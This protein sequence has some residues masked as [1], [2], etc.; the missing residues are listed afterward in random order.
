[1]YSSDGEWDIPLAPSSGAS[2]S[3]EGPKRQPRETQDSYTGHSVVSSGLSDPDADPDYVRGLAQ[4][5]T[6]PEY[7][8]I[9]QKGPFTVRSHCTFLLHLSTQ[10][11]SS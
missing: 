8:Q 11:P 1:M 6:E 5:A 3:E 7:K 9:R 4:R 2:G 10:K